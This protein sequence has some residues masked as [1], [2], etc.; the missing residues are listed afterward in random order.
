MWHGLCKGQSK[1]LAMRH[2]SV[3]SFL[4]M[5]LLFLGLSSASK[6][7]FP[8]VN[9]SAFEV[10]EKLRYRL[11]YGVIDAGEVTLYLDYTNRKGHGRSLF[12]AIGKGYTINSFDEIF[13]VDDTYETYLDQQSIMPWYFKRRVD[14]GGYKISQDYTFHHQTQTVETNKGKTFTIPMG[15]QDMISA[16]YYART[17]TLKGASKGKQFSF[18]V[19]MDDEV[20]TLKIKYMGDHIITTD[21]GK[22]KCHKFVPIVQTGRYFKDEE[23]VNFYVTA[24]DNKLPVLVKA[25]LPV[26]TVRMHIVGY[27]NLRN[28]LTSKR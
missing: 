15:A 28:P 27:T 21:K 2:F 11:S 3:R 24:D 1:P 12:H 5:L 10:G 22:F 9:N 16:F 17:L 23:D 26:G 19:F 18:P 14:E 25:K 8:T 6:N 7:Q 4:L 13:K 20:F